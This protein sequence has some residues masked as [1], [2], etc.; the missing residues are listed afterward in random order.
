MVKKLSQLYMEARNDLAKTEDLQ[1]ATLI[2]RNILCKLTDKTPE[3]LL[4]DFDTYVTDKVSADLTAAILRIRDG[5][6]LAYV[7]GEWDFYGM[8]LLVDKS[9]SESSSDG[10]IL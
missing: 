6:P 9:A 1:T 4:A 8:R 5:E 10:S 2:A 7:L 3:Q